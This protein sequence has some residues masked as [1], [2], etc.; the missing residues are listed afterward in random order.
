MRTVGQ[1][2]RQAPRTKGEK[3]LQNLWA[4]V[5]DLPSHS[6]GRDDG[7]FQLGGDS[8]V[9]MRLVGAAGRDGAGLTMAH[10]FNNPKLSDLAV[11]WANED[12]AMLVNEMPAAQPFSCLCPG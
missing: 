7:F 10:V 4:E 1:G 8:M 6:I 5:L 2:K 9:A 11:S 3:Q 12:S